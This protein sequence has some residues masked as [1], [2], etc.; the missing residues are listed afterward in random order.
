MIGLIELIGLIIWNLGRSY[1]VTMIFTL[2]HRELS[3]PHI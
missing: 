3:I 1:A 2:R